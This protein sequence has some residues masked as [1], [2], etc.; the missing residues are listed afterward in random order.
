[1]VQIIIIFLFFNN[2]IH[3]MKFVSLLAVI[4]FF[5]GWSCDFGTPKLEKSIVSKS[6]KNNTNL[7]ALRSFFEVEFVVYCKEIRRLF[8]CNVRI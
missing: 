1:M 4:A 2:S 7:A 6:S 3:R 8:T 5:S